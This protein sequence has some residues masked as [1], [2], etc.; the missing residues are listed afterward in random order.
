MCKEI[1]KKLS[2][3]KIFENECKVYKYNIKT[4]FKKNKYFYKKEKI[5]SLMKKYLRKIKKIN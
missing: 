5:L 1:N 4:N 2:F 3:N